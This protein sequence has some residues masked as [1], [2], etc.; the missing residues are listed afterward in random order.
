MMSASTSRVVPHL[1]HSASASYQLH[2]CT[3]CAAVEPE[4][5]PRERTITPLALIMA[6]LFRDHSYPQ[7]ST[8]GSGSIWRRPSLKSLCRRTAPLTT[9]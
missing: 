9:L 3:H 8:P 1:P 5:G 4:L 7:H 2:R 6:A